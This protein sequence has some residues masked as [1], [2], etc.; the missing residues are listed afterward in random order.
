MD[1]PFR[2]PQEILAYR[3]LQQILKP[4][5]V[6]TADPKGSVL[7]AIR[8]M[9]D[10]NIGFLV[11]LDQDAIAGVVSERDCVRRTVLAGKLPE[12]TSVGEIMV[13]KVV[14]AGIEDTFADC[15]RLMH[16]HAIRHLPVVAK[17]RLIGV[18][19]IRDLLR[20]AVNH[21]ARIIGE[22]ERE[23]MQMLTCTV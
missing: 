11:V 8:L 17:D 1:R 18:V 10:K 12:A 9:D 13:R 5:P 2:R 6:W 16:A 14:T 3:P 7:A 21:H 19:S 22:L 20:E 15:L 23:R 4:G